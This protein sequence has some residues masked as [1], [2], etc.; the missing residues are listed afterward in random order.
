MHNREK[1]Y[2][3]G[4]ARRINTA[5]NYYK[6]KF[7][8]RIQKVALN[9]G[10]TCPNRD[11]TVSTGGCTF[12]NN[13]AF[14]P[15]YCTPNKS[16][17]LQIREGI[18]FHQK[19]YKNAH[20]FLAYFQAYSNTYGSFEDIKKRYIEALRNDKIIGLI[21]GT[22]PDCVNEDIIKF[23]ADLSKHYY[24]VVEFGIE[25]IYDK[26]LLLINRGH[27]FK[28]TVNAL[29]LCKKYNVHTGGHLIF[30]LPGESREEMLNSVHTISCL[31]LHTIKFH[32]LQIFKN[33]KLGSQYLA[34][35]KDFD[36]FKKNEYIDFIVQYISYLN[37]NIIIERI[38]GETQP[39]NN[40]GIQWGIRYDRVLQ[41]VEK[42]LKEKDLW[43]G[44]LC[45]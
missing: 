23:L 31:P 29:E 35:P 15:S 9:A 40:L 32:Q 7:G 34:N 41:L 43:Q 42:E 21:I 10:F 25:S 2:N 3:W 17:G 13:D 16:I 1:V 14:N 38:A 19:R 26:T 20:S 37:E 44:K 8:N 45:K 4:T 6:K 11:G 22:R 24:I 27:T 18:K 28:Q 39:R 33:T 36:L 12:C 30:G 5:S